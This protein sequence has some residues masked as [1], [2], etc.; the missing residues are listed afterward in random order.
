MSGEN[1]PITLAQA[2]AELARLRDFLRTAP[3]ELHGWAS[4]QVSAAEQA[5]ADARAREAR[6]AQSVEDAREAK[7]L[8]LDA[9]DLAEPAPRLRGNGSGAQRP[10]GKRPW[11]L[12]PLLA[13]LAAGI[14]LAVFIYGDKSQ[15]LPDD[16]PDTSS[17][18]P[19]ATPSVDV[20]LLA[21]LEAKVEKD[22]TDVTSWRALGQ[23]YDKLGAFDKAVTAQRSI[24]KVDPKDLN[25]TLALGVA[26]YNLRDLKGAEASWTK[27]L[28]IDPKSAQAYYNLGFLHLGNDQ[29]AKAKQ[30]W[31][32]VMELEPNSTL[33]EGVKTHLGKLDQASSPSASAAASAKPSATPS[34]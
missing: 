34:R 23:M 24:L 15:Q 29:P 19:S 20:Q 2:E 5:V 14:V 28:E 21:A 25:A 18:Q 31:Q 1:K 17:A 30:A 3:D 16:H 11:W 6:A 4:E 12:L 22:P 27:A 9:D 8:G 7:L 10:A 32:K 33:A 13:L 26:Q